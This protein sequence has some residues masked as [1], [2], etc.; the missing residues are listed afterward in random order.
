MILTYLSLMWNFSAKSR[1]LSYDDK[2][3][4]EGAQLDYLTLLNC[5]QQ[6]IPG[7]KHTGKF[8]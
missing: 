3:T 6:V 7:S 8:F 4:P 5:I 2:T 1:N